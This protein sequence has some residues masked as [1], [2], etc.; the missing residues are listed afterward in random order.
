L[1]D[2]TAATAARPAGLRN[3]IAAL[4]AS[5]ASDPFEAVYEDIATLLN[6][7][8]AVG[9]TGPYYIIGNAGRMLGVQLRSAGQAGIQFLASTAV[10][11]DMIA[12]AA[13]ALV[14]ALSPDPDVEAANA[15]TLV[16][17]DTA[18]VTPDTTHPTKSMFQT[19][20][21]ALKMRW[22]VSWALRDPRGLAWLTPTWK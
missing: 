14:A 17:D 6:A 20:T 9:G 2:A 3:G 10:G 5:N 15:A 16:M 13:Q 7:V 22:P 19:A 21:V 1:F 18:P 4:T 12:V 8:G 11:N